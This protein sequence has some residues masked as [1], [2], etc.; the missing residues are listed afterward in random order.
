MMGGIFST[1]EDFSTYCE[2]ALLQIK[3]IK[4]LISISEMQSSLNSNSF[5]DELVGKLYAYKCIKEKKMFHKLLKT[6]I[7]YENL[8]SI[9]KCACH[10]FIITSYCAKQ[11]IFTPRIY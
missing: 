10:D 3:K 4:E 6:M 11:N 7:S 5:I 8:Y 1:S 9:F 2:N